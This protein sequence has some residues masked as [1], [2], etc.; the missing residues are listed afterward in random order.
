[1]EETI[2]TKI[3][4]GELPSEKI[5]EDEETY[6]FLSIG[7][8]N[9]GNTLVI[10]RAPHPDIFSIPEKNLVAVIKTVHKLAPIVRDAMEADGVNI[11]MNN[12]AAA[13][14]SVF[15]AHFHIVPR[16]E[17]DGIGP[18]KEGSYE[19]GELAKVGEKIRAKLK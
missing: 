4:A 1:M 3:I 15:H 5:Y 7:P 19:E 10:H 12:G 8:I 6:A 17:G 11:L 9:P 16:F 18:W 14:Q 2:F 13:G